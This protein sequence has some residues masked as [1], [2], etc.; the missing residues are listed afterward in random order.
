MAVKNEFVFDRSDGRP[1]PVTTFDQWGSSLP[2]DEREEWLRAIDRQL[3]LRQRAINRGD[4]VVRVLDVDDPTVSDEYVWK[5]ERTARRGKAY[6]E[7]W[8]RFWN[9]YL[10]EC[11][12]QF[13]SVLKSD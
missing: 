11:N 7:I 8:L 9:R 4:L 1:G 5:D 6:D 10:T 12:I 2:A 3:Q 13:A